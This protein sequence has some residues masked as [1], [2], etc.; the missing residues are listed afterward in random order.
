MRA[1]EV[2]KQR[3]QEEKQAQWSEA[4]RASQCE[5]LHTSICR[6][7]VAARR[8]SSRRDVVGR[9]AT[10]AVA[11]AVRMGVTCE[12]LDTGNEVRSEKRVRSRVLILVRGASRARSLDSGTSQLQP[13]S[14]PHYAI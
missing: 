8:V 1:D 9:I 2:G 5:A 10:V 7:C 6:L 11:V 4:C 13:Q 14:A 12:G 3:K